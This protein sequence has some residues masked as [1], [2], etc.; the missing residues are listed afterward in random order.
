M[1]ALAPLAEDPRLLTI[2]HQAQRVALLEAAMGF[3]GDAIQCGEAGPSLYWK[4]GFNVKREGPDYVTV[5]YV[6]RWL[7]ARAAALPR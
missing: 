6:E 4:D 2:I 3:G 5:E 7:K 1:S